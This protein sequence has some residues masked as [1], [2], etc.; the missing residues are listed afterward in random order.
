MFFNFGTKQELTKSLLK[1]ENSV[2]DKDGIVICKKCKKPL[3][4]YMEEADRWFPIKCECEDFQEQIIKKQE[5]IKKLKLNS[6]LKGRYSDAN[7]N[8]ITEC[9]ENENAISSCMKYAFYYNDVYKKGQGIYLYGDL[10]TARY[11]MASMANEIINKER[12]VVFIQLNDILSEIQN[13]YK[14]KKSETDILNKYGNIGLLILDNIGSEDY[15]KYG[16][17]TNFVQEKVAQIIDLRYTNQRPTCFISTVNISDLYLKKG[18]EKETVKTI[19]KMATRR[20][21]VFPHDNINGN[22]ENDILF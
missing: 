9:Q 14:D 6:G 5:Y 4:F 3:M 12:E 7:F 10:E 1:K 19:D 15:K 8:S 11:Y 22:K 21:N 18:M 2:L 17:E 20:F 13:A 16:R